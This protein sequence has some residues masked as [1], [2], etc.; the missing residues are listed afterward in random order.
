MKLTIPLFVEEKRRADFATPLLSAR[1][2]FFPGP[3]GQAEHLSRAITKLAQALRKRLDALGKQ[4]RHDALLPWTFAPKLEEHR[5]NGRIVL[6]R[7]TVEV[8]AL[9]VSFMALDRRLA[10]I[11]AVPDRC[12]EVLRGHHVLDRAREILTDHL[13]ALQR[14]S[15]KFELRDALTDRHR[16]WISTLDLDLQPEPEL[17]KPDEQL[18]AL[19]GGPE[20]MSGR[21]ELQKIGRCLDWLYPD[22]LDRTVLHDKEA[23][24][25]E[26][27]LAAD[28][29]RPVLL[30][31]PPMVGKT[32]RARH[33]ERS[34]M[35]GCSH[36]NG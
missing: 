30:L 4:P 9:V 1:P 6:R 33:T 14:E 21:D 27:L 2:L 3:T 34:E 18:M 22:E 24:E 8:R 19:L 13:N 28:D 5:L 11:P 12:F 23:R 26:S 32:A 36:R 16:Q 20:K 31:G 35:S 25:L 7:G 17:P 15:E 10:I 29:R